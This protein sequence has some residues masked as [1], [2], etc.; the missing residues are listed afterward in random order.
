MHKYLK[1]TLLIIVV[2]CFVIV[3][4]GAFSE[5]KQK[6]F[7]CIEKTKSTDYKVLN[8]RLYC[9]LDGN[10]IYIEDV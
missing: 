8:N 5:Q 7:I 6:Q 3:A 1:D 9:N 10:Y 2:A 4:I